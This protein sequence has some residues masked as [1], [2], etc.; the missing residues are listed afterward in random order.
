MLPEVD[1][2]FPDFIRP[3]LAFFR[4]GNETFLVK[5]ELHINGREQ[6]E[7]A[8]ALIFCPCAHFGEHGTGGNGVF[9]AYEISHHVSVTFLPSDYEL[10]APLTLAD[11][12]GDVLEAGQGFDH[13]YTIFRT[14]GRNQVRRYYGLDG[15]LLSVELPFLF[16]SAQHVVDQQGCRLV[17]VDE[18]EFSPMILCAN[19]DTVPIG[20]RGHDEVC[21]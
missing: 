12:L 13:G 10:F 17:A 1:H 9:I 8:H 15:E 20:I 7:Y 4:D 18:L 5:S 16:P 21:V 6:I 3:R 11:S 19:P 14:Y 2:H